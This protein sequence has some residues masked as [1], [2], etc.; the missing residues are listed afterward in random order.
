YIEEHRDKFRAVFITHGHEDHTGGLPYL[1]RQVLAPVYCTPLTAGLIG[2]KLKEHH[3]AATTDVRT[4]LAGESVNVGV[5]RVEAFSVAHSVP[6]SCG[7]AIH[8]PVGVVI[9]TG[10]FKLDHTPVMGQLT[11]LGRLAELGRQGVLLLL[12]DST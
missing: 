3:L 8:T 5:F 9:H 10:D 12:A 2:V 7:F 4:M 11:D 1:L 6:D